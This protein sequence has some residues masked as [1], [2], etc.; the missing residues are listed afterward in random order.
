MTYAPDLVLEHAHVL[1]L[2]DLWRQHFGYGRGAYR[3]HRKRALAGAGRLRPDPAFYRRL[4]R[5]A[6]LTPWHLGLRIEML[7]AVQ[8]AANAA[9]FVAEALGRRARSSLI[10]PSD[11]SGTLVA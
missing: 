1:T 7:L 10:S 11:T 5:S 3:F 4:A 8:Q 2:R 6:F 9:G